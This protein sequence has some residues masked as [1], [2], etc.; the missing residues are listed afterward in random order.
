MEVSMERDSCCCCHGRYREDDA[1]L[2]QSVWA[3]EHGLMQR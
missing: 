3:S 2:R 1:C